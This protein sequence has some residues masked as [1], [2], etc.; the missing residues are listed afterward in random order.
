[1]LAISVSFDLVV[2]YSNVCV[3]DCVCVS[4]RVMTWLIRKTLIGNNYTHSSKKSCQ[5]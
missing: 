1:M 3:Y 2:K 5:L 4:V